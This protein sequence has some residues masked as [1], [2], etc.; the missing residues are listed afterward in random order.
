MSRAGVG[1]TLA[2]I[3]ALAASTALALPDGAAALTPPPPKPPLASTGYA[4]PL[5]ISSASLNVRINPR[6]LATEYY[7][8]Y[9]PTTAYGFQTPTASA[10][11]GTQETKFA[12][13][14]TGLQPGTLYHYRVVAASS[15]GTTDGQ[16]AAFTTKAIPLSMTIT[17]APDPVVFG[18]RLSVFGALS[19]TG[20]AG[21]AVV[22]QADSFPYT[23]GFSN[24]GNS[25]ITDPAGEF[26]FALPH[27]SA[28]ATLRVA[29]V[30][31]PNVHSRGIIEHVAVSVTLHVRP[32][33]HRGFVRFYGTVTPRQ[34]HAPVVLERLSHGHE[35]A[36]V[37][38]TKLEPAPHGVSQF[39]RILRL[40]P[41]TYRVLV[42]DYGS[43]VSGLSH[44]ILVR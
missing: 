30:S 6:G 22:L 11:N 43:Q 4:G 35:Y 23:H 26:M 42:R 2:L 13:L 18:K 29:L 7:V 36:V 15:A 16:D 5:T 19:G 24:I 34:S 33:T 38:H 37:G 27:L 12:V 17:T 3:G 39:S 44:S 40:R 1:P 9:G 28:S 31:N 41:G 20:N 25:Q 10:G 21:V 14:V 32:A 8:Q